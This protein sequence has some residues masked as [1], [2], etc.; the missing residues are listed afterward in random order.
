M[1]TSFCLTSQ[2][3]ACSGCFVAQ[4]EGNDLRHFHDAMTT[5]VLV[6]S[7]WRIRM[8]AGRSLIDECI[9]LCVGWRR[10]HIFLEGQLL[11]TSP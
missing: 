7:S 1:I 5:G 3:P 4:G 9:A 8:G 6:L 2:L 10:R 11:F